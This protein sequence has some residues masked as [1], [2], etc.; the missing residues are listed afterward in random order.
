MAL[1][2]EDPYTGFQYGSLVDFINEKMARH[3]KGPEFYLENLSLSWEEIEDKIKAV[4]EDSEVP[5]EAQE[6]CT[7]GTLALGVR[8]ARRQEL[9]QGRRVQWLYDFAK[10]HKSATHALA[11]DLKQL[12]EQQEV[13]RKEA[14]FQ[15]WLIH[16]KLA[17]VQK[18]R[19]LL[20]WKLVQAE[21][22][23]IPEPTLEELDLIGVQEV[24]ILGAGEKQAVEEAEASGTAGGREKE[25]MDVTSATSE[26]DLS[27]SVLQFLGVAQQKNHTSGREKENDTR[28]IEKATLYLSGTLKAASTTSPDPLPVQL[29]ASFTY[30]YSSPL[31]CFPAASSPPPLAA[32]ITAPVS[33]QMPSHYAASDFSWWSDVWAQGIDPQEHQKKKRDLEFQQ[34]KS[35]FFRKPG[36]W[37]CPWCKA[38]NFSRRENCFRCRRG[39]WLQSP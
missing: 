19:D 5:R 28:P 38:V 21:L 32:T 22:K 36:D 33:H 29:P 17:Q 10:L 14:A 8:L 15:L 25:E 37:N 23:G 7:W 34:R 30:S 3:T 39:I 9:L 35:P 31:S 26:E 1:R 13:E 4:L 24:E 18:E 27:D 6:A 16:A 12:I 20:R 2:P 11:S